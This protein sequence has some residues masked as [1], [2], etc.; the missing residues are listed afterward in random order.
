MSTFLGGSGR[1]GDFQLGRQIAASSTG[2]VWQGRGLAL[3]R[4][5]VLKQVSGQAVQSVANL[6]HEARLLAAF[7][8]PNIVRVI[9]LIET[10]GQLWL[11]EEWIDGVALPLVVDNVGRLTAAQAV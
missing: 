11:V 5:V 9:D 1:V 10:P 7:A 6:R 2:A 3:D 8:H 4:V